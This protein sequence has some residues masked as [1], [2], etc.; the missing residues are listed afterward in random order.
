MHSHARTKDP[1]PPHAEIL[2]NACT[3]R[4]LPYTRYGDSF[5]I[6]LRVH[7]SAESL[8]SPTVGRL[9]KPKDVELN[10]S[11]SLPHPGSPSCRDRF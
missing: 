7:T 11:A 8:C 9:K 1:T 4:Q 10:A 3:N 6:P 5:E 2:P